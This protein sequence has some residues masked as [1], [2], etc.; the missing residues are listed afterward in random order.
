MSDNQSDSGRRR[1][2]KG[3]GVA[4]VSLGLAGCSQGGDDSNTTSPPQT[5]TADQTPTAASG[6]NV[7]EGGIFTLGLGTPPKG[8]N[9]LSTNSA[10]SS[11]MYNLCYESGASIDPVNF[12][13]HPNVFTDWKYE[14]VD[15]GDADS[16]EDTNVDVFFNVRD[17]L[18][19]NDG[20]ELTVDQVIWSYN[21]MIEANPGN[22][23]SYLAPINSVEAADSSDWDAVIHMN[24]PVGTFAYQQLGIP[25]LPKH[26]WEN[27]DDYKT[28]QPSKNGGPIGLG[29]GVVTK[30]QPDTA[31]EVSFAERKG[32]YKLG[33]LS[34]R[35]DV[36][37]II[38]GGPF[39]DAVRFKIYGST[40]AKTQAFM[41]GTVD[42]LY[43][44]IRTSKVDD[45]KEAQGK[46][47]VKGSATSYSHYSFNLRRKPLD[48]LPFRQVFGFCYDDVYWTQRLQ[49]GYVYEGDFPIPPGYKS[50]RPDANSESGVLDG[51]ASQAFHF[52]QSAPG[53]PDVA[54]IRKFLTEGKM[55]TGD[56]GTYAGKEYPGSYTGVN[57]S[58][59]EPKHDYS[60]GPVKS[61][62]LKENQNVDKEIRVNGK[63]ITEMRGEPMK[64]LVYPAKD[65][66][67][68]AKM[69]ENY[70]NALQQVGIP[71][72]RKV[73]SFNTMTTRVYYEEDF[74]VYPM[75]WTNLSPFGV[76]SMYGL[77]HSSQADDHSVAESEGQKKNMDSF[78]SNAMGYGLFEDAT[79]D[80]LI[81]QAQQSLDA[82]K[83]NKLARQAIER[84]Y[85]D[86]PSMIVSYDKMNWP[87]NSAKWSGF[88]GNIAGPGDT[89]LGTQFL[90]IHKKQ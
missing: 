2:L 87:V 1:F 53:V 75:S 8:L 5:T 71:I 25:I 72:K 81:E 24:K 61:Q 12:E 52:R 37:G 11:I 3:T 78:R 18:T 14:K 58:Q 7:P 31:V 60:F 63:T 45:V 89:Y 33:S 42:S 30:Y 64:L 40:S 62:V 20:K 51:G 49:R 46:S 54:A 9:P 28:Y 66:P 47:L 17:G 83:R 77:F 36:Q 41:E 16:N 79:A 10:Y 90:Q 55:I 35:E 74:D 39:L 26:V 15:D 70:I 76:G 59:S 32:D 21:Y 88:L 80:K 29:P 69:V 57:A 86:F 73:M 19:W 4:A 67:Q 38:S 48:D 82:K 65:S 6:G 27:V 13:M 84:I 85:L 68:T 56:G 34:W 43:S 22:W 44:T 50:V 23:A